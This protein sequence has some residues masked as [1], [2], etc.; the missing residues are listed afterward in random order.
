MATIFLIVFIILFS[1][2]FHIPN[3]GFGPYRPSSGGIYTSL[4]LEAIMPTTNPLFLLG[5]A[6]VIYSG[7]CFVFSDSTVIGFL[8]VLGVYNFLYVITF[9]QY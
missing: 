6:I 5:Y 2:L 4:S 9:V 7:L 3:T 8:Y 1:F